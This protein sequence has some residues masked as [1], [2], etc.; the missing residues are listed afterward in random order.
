MRY[1]AVFKNGI[2]TIID[3]PNRLDLKYIVSLK[4]AKPKEE[5]DLELINDNMGN[6]IGFIEIK[7]IIYIRKLAPSLSKN[8]KEN[9]KQEVKTNAEK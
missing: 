2:R 7:D 5:G 6:L 9:I 3:V 8:K 1:E 4:T